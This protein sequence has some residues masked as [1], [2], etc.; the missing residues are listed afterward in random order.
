MVGVVLP[1]GDH[2]EDAGALSGGGKRAS[3]AWRADGCV[4]GPHGRQAGDVGLGFTAEVPAGGYAWW[5]L[6]ALSSDGT[7]GLTAIAFIGSVF[8][9]Y[10]AWSRRSASKAPPENFV[11]LNVALYMPQRKLWSMTE[12]GTESLA[13]TSSHLVIGPS[14]MEWTG[15]ALIVDIDEI[16]VPI[17]RRIR[18][19]I[20][21]VPQALTGAAFA[22]DASQKHKWWPI[23]PRAIIHAEF[24]APSW[25]WDGHG[26]LDCNWGSEPLEDAFTSWSWSR[27]PFADETLLLYD[28]MER[29]GD[30]SGL[31]LS[32]DDAGNIVPVSPSQLARLPRSAWRLPRETRSENVPRLIRSLEDAPFY[33][34]ASVE[35]VWRGRRGIGMHEALSLDRFRMPLV[36]AML[37]FRMPRWRHGAGRAA[38]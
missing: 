29:S 31:A 3:G 15:R 35:T 37:P 24:D 18:G 38:L 5:Y 16:A 6:D 20:E 23:A 21:L 4:V 14:R 12:R 34:R 30:K 9:P 10:Y 7:V 33:S 11:S 17:P 27:T 1:R 13:R 25:N 32:A 26:Y 36:Q 8:S 2:D 22:L 28:S 19:R